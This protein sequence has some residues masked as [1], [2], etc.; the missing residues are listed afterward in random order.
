MSAEAA[1][2]KM[3]SRCRESEVNMSRVM[4]VIGDCAEDDKMAVKCAKKASSLIP[5]NIGRGTRL[6]YCLEILDGLVGISQAV[7][8]FCSGRHVLQQLEKIA[9]FSDR[10]EKLARNVTPP[11]P[12][13]DSAAMHAMRCMASWS[14]KYRNEFPL[15]SEAIQKWDKQGVWIASVCKDRGS[16]Q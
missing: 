8:V 5:A 10:A 14:E 1:V 15:Y 12:R 7:R 13:E 3:I 9:E 2:E 4:A 16:I 6:N 11:V